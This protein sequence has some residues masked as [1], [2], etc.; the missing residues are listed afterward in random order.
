MSFRLDAGDF[1]DMIKMGIRADD[2]P[3]I[4]IQHGGGMD[5]VSDRDTILIQERHSLF[6]VFLGYGKN[7]I[8][9]IF[10]EVACLMGKDFFLDGVVSVKDFL[11]YFCVGAYLNPG[12]TYLFKDSNAGS[13]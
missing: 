7:W 1:M 2:M 5:S 9:D 6:N 12:R 8:C 11:K 3:D 10:Q 4:M 13:F